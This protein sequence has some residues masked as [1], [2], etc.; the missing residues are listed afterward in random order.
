MNTRFTAAKGERGNQRAPLDMDQ[1]IQPIHL[2][3]SQCKAAQIATKKWFH[4]KSGITTSYK[5]APS[6]DS[7]RIVDHPKPCIRRTK[8]IHPTTPAGVIANMD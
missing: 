8:E 5:N 7:F 3:A 2:H 4:I 6:Q 1:V